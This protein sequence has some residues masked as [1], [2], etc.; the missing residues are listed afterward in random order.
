MSILW[1]YPNRL[2]QL[3]WIDEPAHCGNPVGRNTGPARMLANNALIRR[4]VYAI[5]LVLGHIAVEP[6][7]LWTHLPYDSQGTER[8]FQDLLLG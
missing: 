3:S 4:K 5:D 8:D 1:Q 7:N 2:F 6:L